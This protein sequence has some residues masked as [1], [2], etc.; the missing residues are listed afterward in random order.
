MSRVHA[1]KTRIYIDEFNF[2]GR[3][4]KAELTIDNGLPDV[5]AFE[6]AG[7]ASVEGKYNH[8]LSVSGFFDPTDE[9]YDEQMWNV[10]GDGVTHLLGMYPGQQAT[11]GSIGYELQSLCPTQKRPLEVAGAVLLDVDWQGNDAIVRSTVLAN[12]AVTGTGAVSGS[13]KETGVTVS[14]ETF[15]AILRVLSVSGTGSLTVKIQGSQNDGDPD[16]YADLITFT[17]ATGITSERKTT[18]SATEAWKRVNISAF[19]GFA[20]ATILVVVGKEKI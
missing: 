16:T 18:T 9:G 8:K 7:A 5:T 1:S 20:S 3:T 2:S 17:A 11:A 13:N 10:I 15:V 14:G 12:G 6:D 4:N 19:S